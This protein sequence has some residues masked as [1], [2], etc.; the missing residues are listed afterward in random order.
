MAVLWAAD[1]FDE[2]AKLL[3]QRCK[4]LVFVFNRLCKST[5]ALP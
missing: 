4:D 5:L 1:V 2:V 3:A